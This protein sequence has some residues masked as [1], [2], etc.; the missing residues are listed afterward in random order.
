MFPPESITQWGPP[1]LLTLGQQL[2]GTLTPYATYSPLY[3]G[4]ISGLHLSELDDLHP[5]HFNTEVVR[6][7]NS[8][9]GTTKPNPY[10]TP[11]E[12]IAMGILDARNLS[13][14]YRRR[15]GVMPSRDADDGLEAV[16][17]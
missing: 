14:E 1:Q 3:G 2:H 13:L 5:D 17:G 16:Y 4:W 7:I 15:L 9:T 12:A 8:L 10:K 11:Y 6:V